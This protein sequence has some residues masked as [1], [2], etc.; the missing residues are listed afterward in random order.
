MHIF[1]S[2][3]SIMFVLQ[4]K[5]ISTLSIPY[6]AMLCGL[7]LNISTEILEI[8]ISLSLG[9]IVVV[10]YKQSWVFTLVLFNL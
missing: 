8:R 10:C 3:E 2:M 4:V 1:S 7:D 5:E 6:Q 9:K